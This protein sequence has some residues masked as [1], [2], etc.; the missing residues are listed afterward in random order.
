IFYDGQTIAN[1]LVIDGGNLVTLQG[2]TGNR[3][4][5]MRTWGFNASRTLT[6]LNMTL[7]GADITGSQ[8]DANGAAIYVRNQSANFDTEVP[9]LIVAGVTFNENTSRQT[10]N[11]GNPYDY[12]GGAIYILGGVLRVSNS[13]FLGNT[14]QGGAGGAIHVLGSNLAV[15]GSTFTNNNATATSASS[16]NSGFAGAIY[17]DGTRATGGGSVD[18]INT[19]FTGNNA[20]NQGGAAYVNL[21]PFR[22]SSW[23]IEGSRFVNNR[24]S[25]GAMGLGGA[26]SGG[27]TG[28]QGIPVNI[29]SSY[30]NGNR[31]A[32]GN[33]GASGGAVAFAQAATI[34]I[35]NSTFVNNRAEG[36]CLNCFNANG[37]AIYIVNQPVPF[38]IIN[39]T[40]ANNYAGWVGGGLTAADNPGGVLRNTIFSN[41]TADNGGNDW[42]IQQHC[43]AEYNGVN[44]I[45]FPGRNPNPN[46]F[47]EVECTGNVIVSPPLLT[48]DAGN[49]VMTPAESSPAVDA[50]NNSV[51]AAAPINNVD[52]LGNPRPVGAACDIGAVELETEP[53]VNVVPTNAVTLNEAGSQSRTYTITL[54]TRPTA[55]VEIPVTT[56]SAECTITGSPV[57]L[58][59]NNYNTGDTV[60]VRARNDEI[61]DGN[62]PCNLWTL[63]PTSTDPV[64]GAFT[65]NDTP[66]RLITIR[67]NDSAGMEIT[68]E[69]SV[70]LNESGPESQTYTVTLT[71][72]PDAP[73]TMVITTSSNECTVSGSPV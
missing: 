51:C 19:T 37:G 15:R 4:I 71:A 22:N 21:Y 35:G 67:D 2:T 60:T 11:A 17:V 7:E 56:S 72:R 58:N 32:G 26:L 45:Q 12:G 64:Y 41:N 54:A 53:G 30:F 23:N 24:V 33:S 25:G 65:A 59:A 28:S 5:H 29:T 8:E 6:L 42:D 39:T 46:F 1:D 66:N 31:V 73:V 14:S 10:S 3:I 69:D 13:A 16:N 34:T 9:T 20:A 44:N 27:A 38:E 57:V 48:L 50:G 62:L 55:P 36:V 18:F 52:Q 61:I 49:G 63:A 47:N 70:R 40:I 43:S 68:P